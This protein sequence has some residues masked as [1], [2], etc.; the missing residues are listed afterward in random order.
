MFKEIIKYLETAAKDT[1]IIQ[2]GTVHV[3][4]HMAEELGFYERAGAKNVLWFEANPEMFSKL[5]TLFAD[6]TNSGTSHELMNVC[7][8]DKAEEVKFNITNHTQSSSM[9]DL[10]EHKK[11]Y[12]H[13]QVIDTITILTERYDVLAD[14]MVFDPD[15]YDFLCVDV[16]GAELKVLKGF[17]QYL[18]NFT[19]IC[20]E[21]N[22]DYLYEGGTLIT[23]LDNHL[24]TFGFKRQ[25][26]VMT[27]AK[28]GEAL[29][30]K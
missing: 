9:L 25:M 10:K 22:E 5:V 19:K 7:L 20:L 24:A 30:V 21:V 14:R 8:S 29:Y 6:R 11:Y 16:Q 2:K 27:E 12:P 3:G 1:N 4:A 15:L 13:I 18:S 23:E 17:G 26:T 28:W